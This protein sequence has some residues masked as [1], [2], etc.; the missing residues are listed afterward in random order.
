MI[1]FWDREHF[2][3]NKNLLIFVNKREEYDMIEIYLNY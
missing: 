2:F 3:E 1:D